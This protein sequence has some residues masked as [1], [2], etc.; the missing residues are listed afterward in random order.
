[1]VDTMSSSMLRI[2][3]AMVL[4]VE[5]GETAPDIPH[6]SIPTAV[7]SYMLMDSLNVKHFVQLQ[8]TLE[9]NLSAQS[10]FHIFC[11]EE[12][13]VRQLKAFV[14]DGQVKTNKEMCGRKIVRMAYN[15]EPGVFELDKDMKVVEIWIQSKV[16]N[17]FFSSQNLTP[18]WENANY[19]WGWFDDETG[20]WTGAVGL[21]SL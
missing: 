15:H 3:Y 1:M 9:K 20:R 5:K 16:L 13:N 7:V 6:L 4:L 11:L 10:F 14:K 12:S 21:V 2:P 8:V 19:T 17:S 18:V